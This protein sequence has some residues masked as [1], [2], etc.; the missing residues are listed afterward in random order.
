MKII[1]LHGFPDNSLS[2]SQQLAHFGGTHQ[3][4]APTIH[5][6]KNQQQLE[7]IMELVGTEQA[8]LVGHDM[9]GVAA[10]DFAL[11]FP[12]KVKHLVLINT[13]SLAMFAHRLKGF[14]QLLRSSYMS[15]FA[16]PLV[17][18]KFFGRFTKTFLK[19][20]YDLGGLPSHD[21]L[22]ESG[23]EVLDGLAQYKE[24]A[25]RLP[26]ELFEL[27]SKVP[28]PTTVIFGK[29]DPFLAAPTERELQRFFG[30]FTLHAVNAGHWPHRTDADEV[31][32]II[33]AAIAD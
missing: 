21:P 29:K 16:N 8:V 10:V 22:R 5:S 24:L 11:T 4:H 3:C 17:N 2:W 14:D 6:L 20:A 18:R 9:G 33:A 23:A 15:V 32:G 19:Y 12:D 7:K 26:R 31:N 25:L 30:R 1:F 28:V 13:M 27:R